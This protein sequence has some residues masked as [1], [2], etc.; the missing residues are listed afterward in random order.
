M[1]TIAPQVA[2]SVDPVVR[3]VQQLLLAHRARIYQR[4]VA[5]QPDLIILDLWMPNLN[6]EQVLAQLRQHTQTAKTPVIV[7]S[8][9]KDT[10]QIAQRAAAS[11]FLCKPYNIE[12]LEEIVRKHLPGCHTIAI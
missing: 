7:V 4:A 11:D 1:A 2:L 6:G 5:Y 3:Q 10:R 9:N 12:A 8:A